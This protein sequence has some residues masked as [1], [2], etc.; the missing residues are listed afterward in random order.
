MK[1]IPIFT[2]SILTAAIGNFAVLGQNSFALYQENDVIWWTVDEMLEF[3]H[4]VDAE[5]AEI[6][7]A[8]TGCRQELY[9]NRLENDE[10][11]RALDRFYQTHHEEWRLPHVKHEVCRE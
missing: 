1:K 6:C 10:K 2:L 7:G 4:Q 9:F 3:S 11:Y 8:D 5:T